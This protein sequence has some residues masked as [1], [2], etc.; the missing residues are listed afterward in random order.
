MTLEAALGELNARLK[1]GHHKCSVEQRKASLVLRSTLVDRNDSTVKRRQRIA[2]GLPATFA[3][4]PEAELRAHELSK[5]LR[6]NT[7]TWE[8]WDTPQA[9]AT[10]TVADFREAAQQLHATKYAKDPERGANAWSKKWAPALRKL[11]Y[12]GAINE[13]VLLRVIR[14]L[15]PGTASRRDQGNLL[16]QV[17]RTLGIPHEALLEACRGYGVDK[18]A[19]RDIPSDRAIEAALNQIRLPHWQWTFGM[20]AAYGL[21][22]HE[23]AQLTWLDDNWIEIHDKTKT[24]SRRVTP[25]PSTWVDRFSLRTLPRPKQNTQTLTK[26]FNDALDRDGISIKPYNLRHAYALR[27]LDRGV[28]ADLGARLMGHSLQVHQSTYQRWIEA[29]RIQKALAPYQL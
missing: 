26:T 6:T 29:D 16:T 2:L 3:S 14:K 10:I 8:A 28:S 11:P 17:A 27:L 13:A 18:L 25:C 1:A 15:P 12:S 19:E 22:P 20:C 4:L 23:C 5:Q 9:A 24:G 21:R 7:F